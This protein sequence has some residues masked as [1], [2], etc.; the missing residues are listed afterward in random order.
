MQMTRPLYW[1][2]WLTD[3]KRAP[4]PPKEAWSAAEF[5]QKLPEFT[6]IHCHHPVVFQKIWCL[7]LMSQVLAHRIVAAKKA[8]ANRWRPILGDK[9]KRKHVKEMWLR[10]QI[11]QTWSNGA[12]GANIKYK[13]ANGL[14]TSHSH[15]SVCGSL[16]WAKLRD[17]CYSC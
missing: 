7:G 1:T 16:T 14:L 12:N 13:L 11:A 3:Q 4:L 5:A 10:W 6:Y 15:R 9:P 17:F 8:H 2:W